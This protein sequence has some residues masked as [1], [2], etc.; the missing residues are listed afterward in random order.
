MI[1]SRWMLKWKEKSRKLI[2]IRHAKMLLFFA[3]HFGMGE[4]CGAVV[5]DRR[6]LFTLTYSVDRLKTLVNYGQWKRIP[7]NLKQTRNSERPER[8]C[9]NISSVLERESYRVFPFFHLRYC[10]AGI[11]SLQKRENYINSG[12]IWENEVA[13]VMCV[14]HSSFI[15]S[16][17]SVCRLYIFVTNEYVGSPVAPLFCYLGWYI[18]FFLFFFFWG[19]RLW[20][21]R[22]VL[23][24]NKNMRKRKIKEEK[25]GGQRIGGER[26]AGDRYNPEIDGKRLHEH[27]YTA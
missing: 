13:G 4:N 11:I 22:W 3:F 2:R 17:L 24:K 10:T 18:V 1:S 14:M 27:A 6:I 5:F 8:N 23:N 25:G 7:R 20:L 16:L 19:G 12:Q 9:E 21:W 26:T 15:G